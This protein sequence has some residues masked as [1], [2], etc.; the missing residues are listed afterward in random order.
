MSKLFD[1]KKFRAS[2]PAE[3]LNQKRFVRYFLKPKP[4][5]G[6]AKIPLGNHSDPST[7]STFDVCVAALE[8]GKEQGIGYNFFG[9]EIHGLD[10]DHC[11]NPQTGKICSE[12]MVL[13]SRLGS[14]AEYSVSGQGIHVFFKGSVR[15]KQLGETCL[16]YWNP[17]NSPRFFALTCDMVGEAFT[18][19]KDVGDEFNY[20]FAT[21][22]HISAKIRE[23][24]KAV[25]YEQWEALPKERP[26]VEVAQPEKAKT[27]SRKLHPDFN[28]ADFLKFYGLEIDNE[29]DN[30]LG[31]CVRLTTCPIKGE[32]HVGQN[33][34]TTNFILSVD[35]GLGFH[36]QSTGCVDW[37]VAQ[38]IE[39]LA[40]EKGAY[41]GKIYED[42]KP[43]D[44][45]SDGDLANEF[46]ASLPALRFATDERIWFGYQQGVWQARDNAKPEIESFLRTIE[47]QSIP[48]PKLMN[49]V[50]RRLTSTRAVHAVSFFAEAKPQLSITVGQFDP[51]PMLLGLPD[52]EVLEL[53]TGKRRAATP[54]DLI[55]R[56][57][58]VAP[59]GRCERW[60]QYLEQAHPNDPELI[61]YLQRWA[62]Y[63]LTAS[64][65]ED[66]ILFLI[67]VGGSGKGTF[68]EPLQ[69][70]LGDYCVS[71]P[72]G[73]LLEDTA[74]DR[75]LNYIAAL[76]GARLAICNEG[77]KMRRLDS[78]GIKLL[79][80]GGWITGR[81]LGH[82]PI[83]FKQTHK[84]CVLANDNPVLELDDAMRQRVHVVPFNQ[85]FRDTQK[86]EKGLRE[87]FTEPKQLQGIFN[88]ILEGCLAYQRDGLNPP[89]SV[90]ATTEQFFE[91]MD[92]FERF[93]KDHLMVEEG[94]RTHF[95][96]T[97][98]MFQRWKSHC[99]SE[100]DEAAIGNMRTFA[101]NLKS[102]FPH[103]KEQRRREDG[104]QTRGFWGLK[105][106]PDQQASFDLNQ[107]NSSQ[108]EMTQ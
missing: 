24:L 81:R 19:L 72:I 73:M 44:Y 53:R 102:K 106:L 3:M 49:A 84:L 10:L 108:Q 41:P 30:N 40:K 75:R 45:F 107:H 33:S 8:P 93:K 32:K 47:P 88:W 83:N 11:R 38:V 70:L 18:K 46:V 36:C 26:P 51:D 9:G 23:E 79:T 16:Q 50:H 57:L 74:E 85:K 25:D 99:F 37:S 67:G 42:K 55:T 64:V 78:R 15:G 6:T 14:W 71:I 89:A 27:K 86:E 17:K 48:D 2:L 66:M 52:G 95:Q 28:L 77:S 97:Q 39:H 22:R 56:A 94:T 43:I 61:A 62:G 1:E 7:W 69:K 4:E 12:A 68:A 103:L 96:P 20:I 65:Q 5:G 87:F 59:E 34:T 80:G 91:D 104:Q 13:L 54:S 21:A 31:H 58:P 100:G 76:R 105:L 63:C 90:T 29:T 92:T 101:A 98:P 35:G 60:L 82:Q